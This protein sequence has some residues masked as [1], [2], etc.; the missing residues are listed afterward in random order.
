MDSR[1]W[2]KCCDVLGPDSLIAVSLQVSVL[3]MSD[4][5]GG[6]RKRAMTIRIVSQ[7]HTAVKDQQAWLHGP[8]QQI[9]FFEA[10]SNLG[11][12]PSRYH[13]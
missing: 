7:E 11:C 3:P 13:S 10:Y 1:K 9:F 8:K 6:L 2:Q 5:A 12:R 4:H